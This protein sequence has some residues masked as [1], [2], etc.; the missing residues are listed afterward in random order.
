MKSTKIKNTNLELVLGNIIKQ[1]TKAIVNAANKQ[2]AP[3]GGVAGIIHSAA[4]PELWEE[5]KKIRGC[6]TSQ[7][8]I[9][10]A[11]KLPNKYVIHTV[12][13]I[14]KHSEN[15][16][17]QSELLKKSYLNS[18]K[19]C[20]KNKIDSVAFPAISTGAFGYPVKE[21]SKIALDTII[22]YLKKDTNIKLVRIV[23]YDDKSFK[24]HKETLDKLILDKPL[25]EKK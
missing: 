8:K 15:N 18:L 25:K 11:Y 19:I 13:P 5:C 14:Y 16:I 22:N 3:G 21:A 10:K 4:G 17:E 20:D 2:L 6:K 12:G 7:A 23:L 9:T 1:N 24:I